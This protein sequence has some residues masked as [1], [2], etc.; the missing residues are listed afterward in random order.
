MSDDPLIVLNNISLKYGSITALED[1]NWEINAGEIHALI[2]EHGAGKSSL[3]H[4]ISGFISPEGSLLWEGSSISQFSPRIARSLGVSFVTQEN[5][6][7]DHLPVAYNLL[8]KHTE[9]FRGFFINQK[10]IF[11]EAQNYLSRVG[12]KISPRKLV[13][14][15]TLP[16]RVMIDIL[17]HL[18]KNPR[19]LILDEAMEKLTAIDLDLVLRLLREMRE[20]GA[21]TLFITHRIDDVY[22]YA[23]R[24]SII[25]NGKIIISEFVENI[26]KI[27]LIKLAYTQIHRNKIP[28]GLDKDFYHLLKYNEAI[29]ELLPIALLVVN[30]DSELKLLNQYGERLLN[31][32]RKQILNG[33]LSYLFGDINQSV[34]DDIGSI[35]SAQQWEN[36]YNRTIILDDQEIN[37]N[38]IIEPIMDGNY[39]L[40]SI[41]IIDDITEQENLRE[42]INV[43]ERLATI[44]LLA[45]G[46]SH[47]IN[48]PLEII[49]N[50]IDVL[51]RQIKD[52][53]SLKY[54]GIIEDE[55]DSIE[56]IVSNLITF[57]EKNRYQD[58]Y[59]DLNE[60][61]NQTISLV[62]LNAI[63]RNVKINF[64]EEK[65]DLVVFANRIKIKQ[66]ILNI[67]KN[68]LDA[69]PSGGELIIKLLSSG[70]AF[71]IL[72]FIDN[73]IGLESG[74]LRNIL[75]P[76][77]TTKT[78][79]ENM[80]LGLSIVFGI[81]ESYGGKI[82]A[83]NREDSQGCEVS[84][85]LPLIEDYHDKI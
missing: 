51:K 38:I 80:G 46:V 75:M 16:E 78:N 67:V 9:N 10:K 76:F 33:S 8:N 70:T 11:V 36:L 12:C 48:N 53:D 20:S 44:G 62:K 4:I 84:V 21:S 2:G 85:F 14:E 5:E 30:R 57:S 29:L 28:A 66:V 54:L 81:L 69:M 25:R 40:G 55:V 49:N 61:A 35:L 18:Y 19:L 52:K 39:Y 77:Y 42:K 24:V 50:F 13:E 59:L 23:D 73:G 15:L 26:D 22:T 3:A 68:A 34:L 58:E 64:Y 71:A 60:L 79:R 47:E 31:R 74:G 1:V 56:Q 41:V 7:F 45:A 37:C 83:K 32:D 72:R 63:K 43:S 82:E 65:R 6:L 27:N 17:R